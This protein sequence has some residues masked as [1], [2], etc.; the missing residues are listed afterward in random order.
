[1]SGPTRVLLNGKSADGISVLDRGLHYGDGVFRT[2]RVRDGKPVFGTRQIERVCQDAS[3]IR[4]S[5]DAEML[6]A[7]V[8]SICSNDAN[9]ILKIILTRGSSDRGYAYATPE[10][11]RL[12]I[13]YPEPVFPAAHW[14]NGIRVHLCRTRLALNP[15]LAGIKHL[16]RLEQVL[17]RQ[18]WQD[19]TIAEGLMLDT[20]DRLIEGVSSNLFVIKGKQL[21]TPDLSRCGISG[22]TREMI[23]EEA[24][25]FADSVQVRSIS[26]ED[27][28][29]AD[30]CFVCNSVIGVWPVRKLEEKTWSVGEMTRKIQQYI[31]EQCL[32]GK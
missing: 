21:L 8:N 16:N 30:E 7:E 4:I 10:N 19:S 17:A 26:I 28:M 20:D 15:V 23:L 25:A 9:G 1:M 31:G 27:L 12:L 29:G 5:S 24:E 14:Q 13:L 3:R 32:A 2:L 11:A 18:E 6:M 22:L